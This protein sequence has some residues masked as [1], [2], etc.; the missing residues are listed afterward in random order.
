MQKS[1][2]EK[3][4]YKWIYLHYNLFPIDIPIKILLVFIKGEQRSWKKFDSF[5]RQ[6]L[7]KIIGML[8]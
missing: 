3:D 4:D 2:W 5:V 7:L 8:S 6:V 1:D